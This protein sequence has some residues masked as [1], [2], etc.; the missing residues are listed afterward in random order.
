MTDE[1]HLVV[2][3]VIEGSLPVSMITDEEIEELHD[4]VYDAISEQNSG[5]LP[6]NAWSMQ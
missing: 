1:R 6:H 2:M 4:I 3:A 5:T